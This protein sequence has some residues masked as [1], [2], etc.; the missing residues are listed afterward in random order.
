MVFSNPQANIEFQ[1]R[2]L[3]T[4]TMIISL[5]SWFLQTTNKARHTSQAYQAASVS[6]S[7]GLS[8]EKNNRRAQTFHLSPV[9]L[10]NSM[11]RVQF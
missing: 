9:R 2:L 11:I 8:L 1:E 6:H 5:K 3:Y 7:F 4:N 10:A